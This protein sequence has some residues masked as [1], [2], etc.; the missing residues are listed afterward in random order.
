MEGI[1]MNND[2]LLHEKLSELESGKPVA[3]IL[4]ELPADMTDIGEL[5]MLASNVQQNARPT[6]SHDAA[7]KQFEKVRIIMNTQK[8]KN[9]N[10]LS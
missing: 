1:K 10:G 6:L 8:V 4:Q 7:R 2:Q 5:I 9:G 3:E